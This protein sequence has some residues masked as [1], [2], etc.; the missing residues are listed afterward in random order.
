MI[1]YTSGFADRLPGNE[2]HVAQFR[3][4]LQALR[5]SEETRAAQPD[6]QADDEYA[7]WQTYSIGRYGFEMRYPPMWTLQEA[8]VQVGPENPT[9]VVVT[10]SPQG[11][12]GAIAPVSVEFSDGPLARYRAGGRRD[13]L[14]MVQSVARELSGHRAGE[15]D[16]MGGRGPL[17]HE[18]CGGHDARK[19]AHRLMFYALMIDKVVG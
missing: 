17:G 10:L 19:G 4:M 5:F 2:E 8:A 3:A 15:P 12:A 18:A 13:L 14:H 16:G 7:D 1:D 6:A 9:E 11:W